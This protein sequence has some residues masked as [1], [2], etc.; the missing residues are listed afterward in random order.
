MCIRDR[1]DTANQAQLDDLN[2]EWERRASQPNF[3]SSHFDQ[4]NIL[5]HVR[6][7]ERTDADGKRVLFLEELQS[8][9]GQKGK[10][11]GFQETGTLRDSD[12][13]SYTHLDVY[14]RQEDTRSG[15]GW[16]HYHW[17]SQADHSFA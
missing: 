14:K 16:K 3:K 13:V 10:K 4:P 11:E 12:P 9:W 15:G 17:K 5:A 6:F 2:A 8:D 7:N 1:R